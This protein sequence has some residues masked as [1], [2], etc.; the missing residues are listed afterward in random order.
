LKPITNGKTKNSQTLH[1][2]DYLC[3]ICKD[4]TWIFLENGDIE[5]CDCYQKYLDDI[6]IKKLKMPIEFANVRLSDFNLKPYK[7]NRAMAELKKMVGS[8]LENVDKYKGK[9]FYMY[10]T[11]KGS[12]K[13]HMLAIIGN[14]LIE[15]GY[16]VRFAKTTEILDTIKETFNNS[17]NNT[18]DIIKGLIDVEFLLID[19]IGVEKV[20]DW[21]NEQFSYIIDKRMT[22]KKTTMFT[23]NV[24]PNELDLSDRI[25]SRINKVSIKIKFPEVSVRDMLADY[26]ERKI[27]K[28]LL[29]D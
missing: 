10:S 14:E 28:E 12:G 1:G 18:R 11:T 8:Y 20:T 24:L 5:R 6:H 4:A 16:G 25:R 3:N 15:R 26:E 13:T 23:S 7:G 21:V 27:V 17:Q 29:K 22:A 19:D 2:D 9:G